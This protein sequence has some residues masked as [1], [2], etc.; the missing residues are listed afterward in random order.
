MRGASTSPELYGPVSRDLEAQ[1]Q[2]NA[3]NTCHQPT[4]HPAQRSTQEEDIGRKR[5]DVGQIRILADAEGG[6][7]SVLS[8]R[9]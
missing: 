8:D 2:L 4:I 5:E 1:L 9:G 3:H 6:S 7:V